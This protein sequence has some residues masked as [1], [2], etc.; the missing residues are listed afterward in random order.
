MQI[1]HY[2]NVSQTPVGGDVVKYLAKPHRL[3]Q[4]SGGREEVAS[5]AIL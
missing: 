4:C 5:A 1:E 3:A 2:Q